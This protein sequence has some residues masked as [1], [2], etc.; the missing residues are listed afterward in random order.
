VHQLPRNVHWPD[1]RGHDRSLFWGIL[2]NERRQVLV[3][4]AAKLYKL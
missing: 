3:D 1:S 4:N 2:D